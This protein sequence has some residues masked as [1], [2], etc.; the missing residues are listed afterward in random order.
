MTPTRPN[1]DPEGRYTRAQ[2]IQLLIVSPNT[3]DKYRRALA[4]IRYNRKIGGYF[5]KGTDLLRIWLATVNKV[6]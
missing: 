4:I 1:I 6:V 3:F 2:S 5:Y